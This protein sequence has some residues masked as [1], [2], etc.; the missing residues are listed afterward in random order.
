[1]YPDIILFWVLLVKNYVSNIYVQSSNATE[2]CTNNNNYKFLK[3]YKNK[4][5]AIFIVTNV[6]IIIFNC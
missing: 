3:N 1:M 6:F 4:H 5:F 2:E